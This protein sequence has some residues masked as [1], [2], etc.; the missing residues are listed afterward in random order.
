MPE[1]PT[2]PD[3]SRQTPDVKEEFDSDL[4]VRKLLLLNL[5]L[6]KIKSEKAN[7]LAK[8]IQSELSDGEKETRVLEL[9]GQIRKRIKQCEQAII[10]HIAKDFLDSKEEIRGLPEFDPQYDGRYISFDLDLE[11][12]DLW[13]EVEKRAKELKMEELKASRVY[14]SLQDLI[15]SLHDKG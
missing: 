7:Q 15:K 2:S 9:S 13:E 3:D 4:F 8:I 14:I 12:S 1:T 10:D 5:Y 11:G 6:Y